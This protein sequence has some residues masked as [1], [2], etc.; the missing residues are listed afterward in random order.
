MSK[1]D[2]LRS[3]IIKHSPK[4]EGEL[5]FSGRYMIKLLNEIEDTFPIPK[6]VTDVTAYYSED[7]EELK[8]IK[9]DD[10]PKYWN[11]PDYSR[12]KEWFSKYSSKPLNN[13]KNK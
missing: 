3:Y 12:I 9:F 1:F 6:L 10:L 7:E 4:Y 2:E 13:K 5:F 11:I 8:K